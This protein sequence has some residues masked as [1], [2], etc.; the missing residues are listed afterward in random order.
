MS[1]HLQNKETS[2]IAGTL[3]NLGRT[4]VFLKES[5]SS[6][7]CSFITRRSVEHCTPHADGAWLNELR[8][9]Q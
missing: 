7:N 8:W 6:C 1:A 3:L 5:K 2:S 4:S 9:S